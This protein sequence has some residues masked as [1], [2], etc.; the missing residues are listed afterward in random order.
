MIRE[1]Q[2]DSSHLV[3]LGISWLK[4]KTLTCSDREIRG[5][6]ALLAAKMTSL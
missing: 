1:F 5:L 2:P 4:E 3:D 6:P